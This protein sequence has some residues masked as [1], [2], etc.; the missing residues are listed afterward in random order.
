MSTQKRQDPQPQCV[1]TLR[2][3]PQLRLRYLLPVLA[4]LI[5][6]AIGVKAQYDSL[7]DAEDQIDRL[8]TANKALSKEKETLTEDNAYLSIENEQLSRDNTDLIAKNEQ[9][10]TMIHAITNPTRSLK[11]TILT[12]PLSTA[13]TITKL[14]KDTLYY[15]SIRL[16]EEYLQYRQLSPSAQPWLSDNYIA[17]N[18]S[19]PK[20]VSAG[21]TGQLTIMLTVNDCPVLVSHAQFTASDDL[22]LINGSKTPSY[23]SSSWDVE[24]TDDG[25]LNV[26]FFTGAT[27]EFQHPTILNISSLNAVRCSFETY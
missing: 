26:L 6:F 23:S 12:K 4:C 19:Y 11:T 17:A 9:L 2:K 25:T 15:L 20:S 5:L 10:T 1:I 27:D 21:E 3:R 24:L 22:R 8:T 13:Q 14:E 16:P 18:I 7:V